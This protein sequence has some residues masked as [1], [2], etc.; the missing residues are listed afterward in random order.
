MKVDKSTLLQI[1]TESITPLKASASEEALQAEIEQC[2]EMIELM[3][4]Q[5][6]ERHAVSH[7]TRNNCSSIHFAIMIATHKITVNDSR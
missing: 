6:I 4:K 5:S 2:I 3:T 7:Q 1:A